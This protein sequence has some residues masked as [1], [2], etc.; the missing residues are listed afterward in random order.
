MRHTK[1][2]LVMLCDVDLSFP[3]A[4]RTHTIEVARAFARRGLHVEL[5]ARGSVAPVAGV[6]YHAVNGADE[7]RTRRFLRL[8]AAT[9]KL[10]ISRRGTASRFYVRDSWSCLPATVAARALR[11]RVVSQVDGIAYGL[12]DERVSWLVEH[13]KTIAATLAGRLC[14]GVLAVTPQIKQL[15]VDL[16]R[17]PPD[18]IVVIGNGVDIDFFKPLQR[19]AAIKR[20][21]LESSSQ[22]AVFC[23]GF[24]PWT[25][26]VGTLEGFA[27][28]A[29][30]NPL[31]VLLL[32]GDGP[33]LPLIQQTISRLS[34][35]RKVLLTGP[36]HDRERIRDYLAAAT[37]TLMV[38]RRE[39]VTR[40]SASP[41][42]LLEYLASG[43]GTIVLD[44][45]GIGDMIRESGGG[46]LVDG[47]PASIA[48]A[49]SELLEPMRADT[50]GAAGRRYAE[51]RLSWDSVVDR[52]MPLFDL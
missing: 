49:I 10:L 32:V 14:N 5:V 6:S 39:M 18:R 25:D 20:I 3:D 24:H 36:I 45:P 12:H 2:G 21:G 26:F 43:R 47:S 38:H 28:A 35:E 22:Y 40:T 44:T 29:L 31:A 46:I 7:Q 13:L 41:I 30:A 1:Q 15:L 27:T 19:E 52:T 8:N 33:E 37:L 11:Y 34:L 4:T 16:A 9:I 23:G 17:I 42:K 48:A 51:Q 50:F